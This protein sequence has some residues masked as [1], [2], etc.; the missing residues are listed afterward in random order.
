MF[1]RIS[2]EQAGIS[3]E[4]ILNYIKTLEEYNLNTHSLILARGNSI[5]SETHYAP[6][7]RD[8]KHRMYSVS[9]SFVGIAIGLLIDEA[10]CR[11]TTSL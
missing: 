7:C 1:E 8:F 6:F 10:K 4:A 11:L 3:S 5:I 9:K 2:P